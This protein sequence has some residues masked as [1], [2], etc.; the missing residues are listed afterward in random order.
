MGNYNEM[1]LQDLVAVN[2]DVVAFV[3][4]DEGFEA[5]M[6]VTAVTLLGWPKMT[7]PVSSAVCLISKDNKQ[8]KGR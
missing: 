2:P 8:R 6:F 7:T 3:T 4:N 5:E 1:R